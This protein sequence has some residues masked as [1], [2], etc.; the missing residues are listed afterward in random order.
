MKS[1]DNNIDFFELKIQGLVEKEVLSTKNFDIAQ[2]KEL[3]EDVDNLI[4]KPLSKEFSKEMITLNYEDGCIR[5]ALFTSIFAIK[6]LFVD[7]AEVSSSNNILSIDET[8]A[9]VI[10]KWQEKAKRDNTFVFSIND[11]K[12]DCLIKIDKDSNFAIP[13][14]RLID[15]EIIIYGEITDIGGKGNPNIHID[16][17]NIVL[18]AACKKDEIKNCDRLYSTCGVMVAAK[19]DISTFEISDKDIKFIKFIDYKGKLEGENLMKFIENGTAAWKHIPDSVKW[20]RNLREDE[21]E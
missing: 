18:K 4:R 12:N 14:P 1:T 3:L 10:S 11:S 15:V 5:L 8:R 6:S 16:T 2:L 17:G 21:D 19:Q 20:K 7:L 9:G 13:Q